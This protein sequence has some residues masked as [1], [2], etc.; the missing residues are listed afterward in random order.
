ML[1]KKYLRFKQLLKLIGIRSLPKEHQTDQ[2]SNRVIFSTVCIASILLFIAMLPTANNSTPISIV[3]NF[4]EVELEPVSPE[5]LN[6]PTIQP[7][8]K[9]ALLQIGLFRNLT[10]AESNQNELAKL[11][12]TPLVLKKVTSKGIMH[13]LVI[14]SKN[15]IEHNLTKEILTANNINHFEV[16]KSGF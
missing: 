5:A 12:L 1:R 7:K 10:G 8:E 14:R 6:L 2:L 11:G 3:D 15:E 9:P 13:S 4:S 16:R